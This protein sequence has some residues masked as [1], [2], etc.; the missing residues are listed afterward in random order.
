MA[1]PKGKAQKKAAK[2]AAKQ[3][4]K[5][6][7]KLPK[8]SRQKK[9]GGSPTS[10]VPGVMSSVNDGVNVG[11]VWKN[12]GQVRDHFN[13]RFEKVADLVTSQTA[14]QILQSLYLNPGNSVLFP[15]FSQIASTYEEYIC[16]LMR[17]WYRGEEYMASGSNTSAGIIAYATNMDPDDTAF[18]NLSQMENYEGSV[19]GPPFAGHFVHSV[20]DVHMNRGRNRNKGGGMALN[21]YFVYS[22]ANQ[23]APAS[24]TSK[25]YDLGL[26]QIASNGTQT[27][28][29]AG[30]LW[31]EHEWTL[32]RRKQETPIGQQALYAHIVEGPAASAA[33]TTAYL[34]STGG[35]LMSGS[36]I[37][38]VSTK[39][40]FSIPIPGTFL[41]V[42]TTTGS[43][44]G[45]LTVS[46]GANMSTG[47]LVM[48]DSTV[49]HVNINDGSTTSTTLTLLVVNIGGT[50]TG[51][52]VTLSGAAGLASGKTDIFITQVSGGIT[53][54]KSRPSVNQ[55]SDAFA[56]LCERFDGLE[57]RLSQ[58]PVLGLSLTS[59]SEPDTPCEEIKETELESS[60]HISKTAAE[61]LLRGL[62]LRK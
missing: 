49:S 41:V 28:S 31:V 7:T 10:T 29:P 43:V 35:I 15:V 34:G 32:I 56:A 59:V 61:Q 33:T 22:S 2:K 8:T 24:S 53:L 38:C 3:K 52:N 46:G 58:A 60:V 14:F 48:Q 47:P 16:H 4:K 45:T 26:F 62:G 5:G 17:F 57:K 42:A 39:I 11:M 1:G 12:S 37:P 20:G 25:F 9:N 50:G 21:Q 23:A 18:T 55:I 51:N 27:A 6:G 19:S 40:A 54:S 36:T 30:E 44:T 13:R